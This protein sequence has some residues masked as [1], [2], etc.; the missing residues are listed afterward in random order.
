MG[1]DNYHFKTI[2]T[3]G[4]TIQG[5]KCSHCGLESWNRNACLQ[6]HLA[7]QF[8][9]RDEKKGFFGAELCT[10]AP[11]DIQ[12]KAKAE[13]EG[14]GAEAE[15][16]GKRKAESISTADEEGSERASQMK[17][18]VSSLDNKPVAKIKADNSVSDFF[19]GTATPHALVEH[20]L[21]T[22]MI[23]DIVAAGPG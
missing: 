19:D 18:S 23:S 17:Q 11:E 15:A 16:K 22:R 7:S 14:K 1:R 5:W 3:S 8:S 13:I 6:Y 21:F 2:S 12:A 4:S 9:L 20:V 10:K